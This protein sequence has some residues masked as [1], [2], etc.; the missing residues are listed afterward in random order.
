MT[1]I[2]KAGLL[3]MILLSPLMAK[4]TGASFFVFSLLMIIAFYLFILGP[5]LDKYFNSRKDSKNV[6]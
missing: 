1:Y 6:R 5:S 2:E 4:E 3:L